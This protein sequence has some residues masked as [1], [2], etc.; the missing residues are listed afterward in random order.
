MPSGC[1]VIPVSG[2]RQLPQKKSVAWGH[3]QKKDVLWI[4]F[5]SNYFRAILLPPSS[6]LCSIAACP[7]AF[8]ASP[9]VAAA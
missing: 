2:I 1:A 8:G 4:R 3:A 7:F 9:A 6:S 5:K